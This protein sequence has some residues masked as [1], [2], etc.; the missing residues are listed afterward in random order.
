MDLKFARVF[1]D[2]RERIHD[3][4]TNTASGPGSH[5]LY[6]VFYI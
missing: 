2:H 5:K 1:S 4:F 3:G 6:P